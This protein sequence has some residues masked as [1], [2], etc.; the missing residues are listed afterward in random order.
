MTKL[1]Q[2]L[3]ILENNPGLSGTCRNPVQQTYAD[4]NSQWHSQKFSTGGVNTVNL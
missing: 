4:L 3:E 2:V 1:N